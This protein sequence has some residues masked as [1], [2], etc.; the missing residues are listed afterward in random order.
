[1]KKSILL[2]PILFNLMSDAFYISAVQTNPVKIEQLDKIYH[3]AHTYFY[4]KQYDK[5]L[6]AFHQYIQ[7]FQNLETN[8]KRILWCI[9]QIERI[10]LRA[11]RNPDA[12]IQFS[13]RTIIS[14]YF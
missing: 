12:A 6:E 3:Q 7:Q 10:Y 8:Q 14:F 11:K 2:H 4:S 13:M 1:M 5:V 9:D